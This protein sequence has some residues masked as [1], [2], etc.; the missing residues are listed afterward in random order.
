MLC[1]ISWRLADNHFT[2][3][4]GGIFHISPDRWRC[5]LPSILPVSSAAR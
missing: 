3:L 2:A 5:E 1:G 4:A